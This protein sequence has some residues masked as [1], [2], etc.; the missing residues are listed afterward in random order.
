MN[1]NI[2]YLII[3]L[4]IYFLFFLRK[5]HKIYGKVSKN[6]NEIK[7][8]LMF[9]RNKLRYN[10]GMLFKMHYQ[11]NSMWMKNTYIP[12]DVIFL[13]HNMVI[14]GYVEDTV[15]LS[16]IPISINKKS[17]YVLEM[18]SGS[19]RLHNMKISDRIMFKEN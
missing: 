16:L 15:P 7:R 9:R 10:E 4:V 14:V 1:K 18:N 5:K 17:K 3:L 8:G 2:L 13:D 12:L 19:I 6:N 11:N